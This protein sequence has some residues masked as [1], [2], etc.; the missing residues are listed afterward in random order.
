V[1]LA[2]PLGRVYAEAL[3]GIAEERGLVDDVGAE[4]DEFQALARRQPEI[5]DFLATPVVEPDV[6]VAALRKAIEGRLSPLVC[7]FLCLVVQKRRFGAFT[8]I[9]DAYRGLADGHAGRV[10]ATLRTAAPVAPSLRDEIV[11]VLTRRVGRRIAMDAEVDP[12]L[13]GG[14]VVLVDDRIYDGSLRSRLK[15]FRKQL[16]RSERP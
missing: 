13:L 9:V 12:A 11:E 6:K 1:K 4:L 10:R 2:D 15:R 3:F 14:A 7:D 8:R 5:G 16:I